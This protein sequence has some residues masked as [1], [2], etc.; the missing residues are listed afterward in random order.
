LILLVGRRV[1]SPFSTL[2]SIKLPLWGAVEPL[3]GKINACEYRA[4]MSLIDWGDSELFSVSERFFNILWGSLT[5][6]GRESFKSLK[7][8]FSFLTV[9]LGRL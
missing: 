4:F 3:L 9:G 8:I 2:L 6:A 7:L 5:L 1:L